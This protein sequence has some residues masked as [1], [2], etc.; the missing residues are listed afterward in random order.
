MQVKQTYLGKTLRTCV[1]ARQLEVVMRVP[2]VGGHLS[3][4][5]PIAA[6]TVSCC[7]AQ[8]LAPAMRPRARPLRTKSP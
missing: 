3:S 4:P 7:A 8:Q 5:P 2:A 1:L 6:R